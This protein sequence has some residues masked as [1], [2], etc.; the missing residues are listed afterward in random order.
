MCFNKINYDKCLI[1]YE[2][3]DA[4]VHSEGYEACSCTLHIL[5]L[6]CSYIIYMTEIKLYI[7]MDIYFITKILLNNL[8][9]FISIIILM[10]Y[11]FIYLI[12]H[13]FL[14]EKT[15]FYKI[16][17]NLKIYIQHYFNKILT[18]SIIYI[19]R[20]VLSCCFPAITFCN[21]VFQ[22]DFFKL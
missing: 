22:S 3:R 15:I 7:G 18:I 21:F 4:T 14:H 11:H 9:L 19:L 8:K 16:N 1:C 12:R 17:W 13:M 10:C 6:E 2:L 5:K 20:V